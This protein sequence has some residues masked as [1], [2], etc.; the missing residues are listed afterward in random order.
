MLKNQDIICISSI[1]WDFIWQGH[2]EIM[3][4]LSSNGN[5]VL[6]IEN[7]GVR[8]PGMRDLPR[9]KKRLYNWLHSVKG[10][11]KEKENL[12]IY[13]PV[14]LPFPYSRI[15]RR[16]NI[17]L[18][19]PTLER[20]IRSVGFSNP[21]VWTF[22]PTGLVL[23]IIDAINSK[24]LIYYCIDNFSASSPSARRVE[25]TEKR[26][27][28]KVDLVFVTAKNLYDR[29]SQHNR[30]V[31]MFPFGVNLE[32]YEKVKADDRI[33]DDLAG[34]EHPIVGYVGGIHKW[35][36]FDLVEYAARTNKNASFVFIGPEQADTRALKS[37]PN[38][39]FLGQKR[40][41][42]LPSYIRNFDVC[43][44]PY[45]VT[46]Y[47]KNV[48]PT[49]LTEYL[50]LGKAVIS[51]ALPEAKMFNER[52]GNVISIAGTKEAFSA[53]ITQA[54]RE[55][56][57][58][59]V[60]KRRMKVAAAEGSW[61]DKIEKM[62]ELI[63]KQFLDKEKDRAARWKDNLLRLY[64]RSR[65]KLLPLATAA[66][67]FYFTVFHTPLIWI[68]GGPLKISNTVDKADA[69]VVLAGGMGESG[70]AG[71]GYEERV[72]Y[73]VNLFKKGYASHLVLVSGYRYVF[74][75]AE[76]MKAL[77]LSM[78]VPKDASTLEENGST[79]YESVK[80]LG[81]VMRNHEWGKAILVS[82]PYHMR[83]LSLVCNKIAPTI[84]FIYA[85]LP[86]SMFFGDEKRVRLKHVLAIAHEY[87]GIIYY[88]FKGYI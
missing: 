85:P 39:H 54:V 80:N 23:D 38:I 73:G 62:S 77:S 21:I 67:I 18:I 1:D 15:A 84:Q 43:L 29:C 82:S 46:E 55:N 6:F 44:I 56:A 69:I 31:H 83:R 11:R 34:I 66:A 78:D 35:I 72:K 26:L 50:S 8:A 17:H 10:I 76:V 71:Q 2:Q 88:Y 33:P 52:N 16:I 60:V 13:S 28:E 81:S 5:R 27:L 57:P 22:L 41:E 63:E 12:Y 59:E 48:Y 53:F 36:D 61:S 86:H 68:M 70:N 79:T 49:K 42:I 7:T 58:A 3:S 19:V 87:I 47:T 37:T 9:L 32:I 74:Q 20:W 45:L 64:N 51:T 14:I 30:N 40:Y 65:K 25:K 75:E 24:V 4:A